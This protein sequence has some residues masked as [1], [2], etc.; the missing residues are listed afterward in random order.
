MALPDLL[1]IFSVATLMSGIIL[2]FV[3]FLLRGKK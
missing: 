3:Y 2:L 1:N